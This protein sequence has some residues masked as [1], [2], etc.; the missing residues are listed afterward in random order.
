MRYLL[1]L[2]VAV[3]LILPCVAGA[4]DVSDPEMVNQILSGFKTPQLTPGESGSLS[5]VFL[6]PYQDNMTNVNLTA[7]IYLYVSL[8]EKKTV[9][10]NWGWAEPYFVEAGRGEREYLWH[11]DNLMPGVLNQE[12]LSLTVVTSVSAPHGGVLNQGSYFIRFELEFD[13]TENSVTTT[14]TLKSRG[15]FTDEEWDFAIQPPAN[16]NDPNYVGAINL[17]HLGVSGILPDTSF[18]ILEPFPE[19]ALYALGVAAAVFL[20]FALLF[21]L[22][23]NPG[24]WPWLA[25]KWTRL[26][27]TFKQSRRLSRSGKEGGNSRK[28]V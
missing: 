26:R 14:H 23:E 11:Y 5:F 3:V 15:H 6:N 24:K 10:D 21:Y 2:L 13:Y 18:G 20:V 8:D 16:A 28:K 25:R 22:E 12:N 19:W 9:D 27:S 1:P 17:T 7:T 4:P